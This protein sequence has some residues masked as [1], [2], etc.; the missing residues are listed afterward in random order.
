[1]RERD[2]RNRAAQGESLANISTRCVEEKK[3][4]NVSPA[5]N[6][7]TRAR[8][9]RALSW[10]HAAASTALA[11]GRKKIKPTSN[12]GDRVP[13]K[14]GSLQEEMIR[15]PGGPTVRNSIFLIAACLEYRKVIEGAKKFCANR[16]V[17][18]RGTIKHRKWPGRNSEKGRKHS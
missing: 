11:S 13:Q 14:D 1:M 15:A 5:D 10:C 7:G 8:L 4:A 17:C 2:T 6:V 16:C 12:S 3:V 9:Q 18:V